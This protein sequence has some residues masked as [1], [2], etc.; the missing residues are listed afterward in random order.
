MESLGVPYINCH[1]AG[2]IIHMAVDRKYAG[3][4]VIS[5]IIKPHAKEAVEALKKAGCPKNSHA[6]RRQ[7]KDGT[8]GRLQIRT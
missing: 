4:I 6:Y 7:G 1:S 8:G 3:H 2:T 5:D